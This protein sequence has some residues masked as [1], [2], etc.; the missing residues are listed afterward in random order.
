MKVAGLV[1]RLTGRRNA[2]S[3]TS[4]LRIDMLQVL[5]FSSLQRNNRESSN[6]QAVDE[7]NPLFVT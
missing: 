7:P 1:L 4:P 2:V 5:K 6:L 3:F